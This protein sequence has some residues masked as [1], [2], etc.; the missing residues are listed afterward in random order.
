[1]RNEKA[2]NFT[3]WNIWIEYS[4]KLCLPNQHEFENMTLKTDD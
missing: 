3:D 4:S 2:L 1:M